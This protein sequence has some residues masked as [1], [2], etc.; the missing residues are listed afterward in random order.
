MVAATRTQA[1]DSLPKAL[2]VSRPTLGTVVV[3]AMTL[4]SPAV[5]TIV[6]Y[7]DREPSTNAYPRRIVSPTRS[8]GCCFG[9]MAD[10]GTPEQDGQ[11][12]FRYR[13]CTTCGFTV[14]LATR[15]LPDEARLAALRQTLLAARLPKSDD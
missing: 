5:A 15:Y 12:L 8:S 2:Y 11:W 7:T 14:R 10:L 9:A 4:G 6:L 1:L 3:S 13:R